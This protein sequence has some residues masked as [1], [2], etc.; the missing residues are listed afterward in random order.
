[1]ST[2]GNQL[3]CKAVNSKAIDYGEECGLL[4]KDNKLCV[5]DTCID[6]KEFEH[7]L[8]A[9]EE[10]RKEMERVRA[11]IAEQNEASQRR[12]RKAVDDALSEIRE[13]ALAALDA[14]ADSVSDLHDLARKRDHIIP[15]DTFVPAERVSSPRDSTRSSYMLRMSVV[16][17]SRMVDVAGSSSEYQNVKKELD[18]SRWKG[19]WRPIE[20][21]EAFATNG[22]SVLLLPEN[23]K[24]VD[25]PEPSSDIVK[26]VEKGAVLYAHADKNFNFKTFIN[27]FGARLTRRAAAGIPIQGGYSF[28]PLTSEGKGKEKEKE[29]DIRVDFKNGT[30]AFRTEELPDGATHLVQP[31]EDTGVSLLSYW[32]VGK[33]IVMIDAFDMYEDDVQRR[34]LYSMLHDFV[35]DKG[36]DL[37]PSQ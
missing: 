9:E 37:R 4:R 5:G 33:G 16:K 10:V 6:T 27:A 34:A 21:P 8:T 25:Y 23:E 24:S 18:A 2:S 19:K 7:I 29:D 15:D 13:G 30:Y 31:K 1:M 28:P 20:N 36:R 14:R 17:N 3:L 22:D 11:T 35:R 12:I 26:K 32:S